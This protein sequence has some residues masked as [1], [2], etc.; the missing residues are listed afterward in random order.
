M[1]DTSGHVICIIGMH[2][3][4]TSMVARLLHQCGLYLGPEDQLLGPSSGNEDGHFEHTGFLAIDYA[5]LRHFNASWSFPP[6]LEPGWE[7]EA[8]LEQRRVEAK[9]LVDTFS[10]KSPWGW[11]EPRATIFLPFSEQ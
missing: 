7:Q 4:G 10:G 1:S 11:K 5:L 3:S 2:R 8:V 6:E 9:A